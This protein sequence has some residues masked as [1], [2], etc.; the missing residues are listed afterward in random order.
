MNFLIVF[1]GSLPCVLGYNLLSG[2]QPLG[3]GTAVLDLEDFIVSNILLPFGSLII[4][5]FC[6]NKRYGWGFGKYLE[7][8]NTGDGLKVPGW[9]R[10]YCSYVL[11]VILLAILIIGLF[12]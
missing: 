6:V 2:W 9:I 7:E 10:P 4:L 1:V 5:L 11:P 12:A 8:A 3:A